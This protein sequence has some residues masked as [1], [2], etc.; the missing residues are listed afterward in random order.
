LSLSNEEAELLYPP[1]PGGQVEAARTEKAK[2]AP[3]MNGPAAAPRPAK[4]VRTKT[5]VAEI[6]SGNTYVVSTTGTAYEQIVGADE[7]HRRIVIMTL[8][9][10]VVISASIAQANDP[11]AQGNAAGMATSG[12]A[13]PINVPFVVEGKAAVWVVAT[14]ST[15]TRVSVWTESYS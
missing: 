9:Q 13:W 2:T 15:A 3:E 11:R 1:K 4:A 5:D 8:D 10:P 14:S 7:K 12:V 6:F